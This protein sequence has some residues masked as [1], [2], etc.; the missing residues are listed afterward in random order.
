M[1]IFTHVAT[2]LNFGSSNF[3]HADW[4]IVTKKIEY[5]L[6][7]LEVATLLLQLLSDWSDSSIIG[8]NNLV[9]WS[10]SLVIGLIQSIIG[11]NQK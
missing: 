8:F 11:L 5:I 2:I 6:L 10:D 9:I 1:T 4:M 3:A 7:N